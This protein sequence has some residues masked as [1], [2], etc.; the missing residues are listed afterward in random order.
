MTHTENTDYDTGVPGVPLPVEPPSPEQRLEAS[1]ARMRTWFQETYGDDAAARQARASQPV[2][3]ESGEPSWLSA[4]FDMLADVPAATVAARWLRRWWSRHPWRTTAD[5]ALAIT[6]EVAE[7]AAKR[8]P[9]LLVGGA[10]VAGMALSRVRPWRW[11]SGGAIVASLVPRLDMGAMLHWFTVTMTDF[12]AQRHAQQQ[13]HA[14]HD[15]GAAYDPASGPRT[16]ATP[17]F[18]APGSSSL[19]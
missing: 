18:E 9:W 12:V 16:A 15:D 8:H 17:P 14:A 3:D 5:L 6:R 19:H 1:R 4:I 10:V 11:I 7:P 2:R 13:G